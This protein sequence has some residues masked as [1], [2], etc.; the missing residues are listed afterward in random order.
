MNKETT[1]TDSTNAN[2]LSEHHE[3]NIINEDLGEN[4]S[5]MLL[6]NGVENQKTLILT[7]DMLLNFNCGRKTS[8]V[9]THVIDGDTLLT[10]QETQ[11][12]Y[13]NK[14]KS[15]LEIIQL[16]NIDG[17][18]TNI[19]KTLL[20]T[21]TTTEGLDLGSFYEEVKANKCK[22]CSFLCKTLD[23]ITIHLKIKHGKQVSICTNYYMINKTS[24]RHRCCY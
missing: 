12:D 6:S 10:Y 13:V 23:E 19:D 16:L 14:P 3:N 5:V 4:N 20:S 22:L 17:S 18:V 8:D 24:H 2:L 21:T 11:T 7:N 15:N 1:E 9:I